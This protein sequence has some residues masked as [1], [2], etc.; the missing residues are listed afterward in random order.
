MNALEH[1]LTGAISRASRNLRIVPGS[2][3]AL[4][5][6]IKGKVGRL[7]LS[8]EAFEA[9]PDVSPVRR[10]R[11]LNAKELQRAFGA[12]QACQAETVHLSTI[13]AAVGL[14]PWQFSRSFHASTGVTFTAYLL[15]TRIDSAMRLMTE[16]DKS[17]CDIA[18]ASGFSDQ[19]SFSRSFVRSVGIT[20]LKWRRSAA[21]L[22]ET[23]KETGLLHE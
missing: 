19:S 8:V 10:T 21:A 23:R 17:L 2:R 3:I 18:L 13:A 9:L 6:Q 14:S 5:V 16:T 7:L 11:G 1:A 12:I 15:R 20:P 4:P 22:R